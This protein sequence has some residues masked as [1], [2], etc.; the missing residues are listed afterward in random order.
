MF[1]YLYFEKQ[2]DGRRLAEELWRAIDSEAKDS[3]GTLF[4]LDGLDEVS[5]L[6]DSTHAASSF[7]TDLLNSPNAII[8]ARPHATGLTGVEKPDLELETIGFF[9]E[10]VKV[11]L[12]KD[13][14]PSTKDR[15]DSF[16]PSEA[17]ACSRPCPDPNPAG[18][19][20]LHLGRRLHP[21]RELCSG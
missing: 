10:Q 1:Y 16:V 11:Y 17:P 14:P 6:L 7:L 8:T 20:L 2:R 4:I 3:R 19:T 21:G 15:M 9:P 18:R 13:D 5:E 12:E